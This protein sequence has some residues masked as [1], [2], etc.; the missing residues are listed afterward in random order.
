MKKRIAWS[1]RAALDKSNTFRCLIVKCMLHLLHFYRGVNRLTVELNPILI[2]NQMYA[3][4][5]L[6]AT[7]HELQHMWNSPLSL[8]AST[9]Q[10]QLSR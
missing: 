9:Y 5:L 7:C 3:H 2:R 1:T 8:E 10:Q 6:A 4:V